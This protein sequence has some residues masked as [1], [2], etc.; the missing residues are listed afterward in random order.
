MT[1]TIDD[2]DRA[3]DATGTLVA[4]VADDQW[5]APTPCTGW[6]IRDVVNHV[7][8]GNH[9]FASSLRGKPLPVTVVGAPPDLLGPD[10]AGSFHASADALVQAF[11]LPGVL[12]REI[13]LPMGQVPAVQALNM[14][15]TEM[16][17]HGWDLARASGQTPRYPDSVI[18]D[19]IAFS[20]V[21]L[22]NLPAGRTPFAPSRPVPEDASPL[23]RL[24]ALLGRTP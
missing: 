16:L 19:Q 24:A 13:T 12:D 2:L 9:L 21:L 23:D 20:R 3:L 14:R 18:E 22:P 17:A 4:G 11:A 8:A 10:P 15:I 1:A 6:S 7:T 5:S